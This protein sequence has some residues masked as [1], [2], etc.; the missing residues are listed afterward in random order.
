MSNFNIL[1][2][3]SSETEN[4]V[5][6]IDDFLTKLTTQI[7]LNIK[8]DDKNFSEIEIKKSFLRGVLREHH[9]THRLTKCILH[10]LKDTNIKKDFKWITK[11][12]PM[13]H[14]SN[15]NLESEEK[16]HYD[17]DIGSS[18]HTCWVPITDYKYSGL[19]IFKYENFLINFLKKILTKSIIFNKFTFSPL[20]KKGNFF[21]WSGNRLHKG[22]L[23]T[24]NQI[25][26][27]FQMKFLKH[28]YLF[29]SSHNIQNKEFENFKNNNI[30]YLEIYEDYIK[31][32][33]L[34]NQ[35]S[36]SI[37][38]IETISIKD[39][40]TNLKKNFSD[41]NQYLSFSLSVLSQ[42]LRKLNVNNFDTI[43][44]KKFHLYDLASIFMGS[45]NLI[46]L[47]RVLMDNKRLYKVFN[48]SKL[49]SE[50]DFLNLCPKDTIQWNTILDAKIKKVDLINNEL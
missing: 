20:L 27:A 10:S 6:E 33:K 22:N 44:Q 17:S 37:K 50:L 30:N 35:H 40:V 28:P 26:C 12:Y 39:F 49:L 36:E 2:K 48:D 42:R 9:L 23:N 32:L 5:N 24:S 41:K 8:W 46:S 1:K 15:D 13:I 3:F 7:N 38:S 18:M 19:N 25:T 16:L 45:E 47:K 11:F 29:E 34:I 31:L 14:L 43:N 4:I 21:I